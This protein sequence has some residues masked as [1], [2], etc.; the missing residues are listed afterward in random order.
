MFTEIVFYQFNII[1]TAKVFVSDYINRYIKCRKTVFRMIFASRTGTMNEEQIF[2]GF[3]A[4]VPFFINRLVG[5][6][7]VI[8][9]SMFAIDFGEFRP[10]EL[11][12]FPLK[13]SA[14]GKL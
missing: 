1:D 12:I 5:I 11:K 10:F 8:S 7:A 6:L 4:R 14:S 2:A 3:I 13:N 9:I